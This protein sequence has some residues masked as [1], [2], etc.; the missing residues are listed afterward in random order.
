MADPVPYVMTEAGT[1]ALRIAELESILR[2]FDRCSRDLWHY[3]RAVDG[4][5]SDGEWRSVVDMA[6]E[7]VDPDGFRNPNR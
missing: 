6:W 1:L 7:M 2:G 4:R 5:P 3:V